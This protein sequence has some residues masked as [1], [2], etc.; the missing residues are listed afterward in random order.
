MI[1]VREQTISSAADIASLKLY[2][3]HLF[4]N[5]RDMMNLFSLTQGR[6]IMLNSAAEQITGY[7]LAE[8][9]TIPIENLYPAAE[10]P[11]LK[12]AF[13]RLSETGY[14][15]EKLQMYVRSGELRDIW[16]RSFIVQRE[17]EVVCLVHTIDVTEENRKQERAVRDARLATLGESTA[18][19]AHEV[20]NALQSIQFNLTLLRKVLP[21]EI[22][23]SAQPVME[24]LERAAMHMDGVISVIQRFGHASNQRSVYLSLPSAVQDA[25]QL[26]EG[27]IQAKGVSVVTRFQEALGVVWADRAQ[28]EQILIILIKN[29]VQAMASRSDRELS[30]EVSES[31]GRARVALRDTGGGLAPSIESRV[32]EAFTTTKQVGIGMGLGLATAKQLAA[33]NGVQLSLSNEPGVGAEFALEFVLPRDESQRPPSRLAG[34]NVLLVGDESELLDLASSA[35]MKEGARVLIAAS[36]AEAMQRLLVHAV[37]VI[38]CDDAM[39]PIRASAFVTKARKVF[40]GPVCVIADAGA[41]VAFEP[42]GPVQCVLR[43]PL[44]AAELVTAVGALLS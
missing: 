9:A 28:I 26:M 40:A 43:K 4:T 24:R 12:L 3:E 29:A 32:F 23:A 10:L 15:S 6:I 19:L 17:P 42:E 7:G 39:Y 20:S 21:G 8:L 33:N 11:K 27:Y 1:D 36:V 30:I 25:L 18:A 44:D 31:G 38:M 16:T 14:S 34:K 2:F 37:D 22:S 5:S 41:Q 13:S 35:L